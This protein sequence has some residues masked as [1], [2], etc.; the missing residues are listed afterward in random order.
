[1]KKLAIAGLT[2][3]LL[4]T[5]LVAKGKTVTTSTTLTDE[6]LDTLVFIYQEEKVARDTYITLGNMYSNQTVFANIQLSEQEHI[7]QAEALCDTYGADTSAI[8]ESNVGEFE[9]PVLQELYDTLIAQGTQSELSALMV[10][11]YIEITDIDDLEHAEEGMPTDVVNVYENL[12]AGSLSHLD[13][14]RAA[15]DV[16]N[17]K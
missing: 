1:M 5:A 11:E 8:D 17:N 16:Y 13:G 4:T 3:A 6:Q 12:K 10:G 9:V 14:F 7:D 2:T 15:I